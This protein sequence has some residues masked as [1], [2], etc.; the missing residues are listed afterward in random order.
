MKKTDSDIAKLKKV[1]DNIHKA[2]RLNSHPWAKSLFVQDFVKNNPGFVDKT[3]GEQIL[4]AL[5]D[6]FKT[7]LPALPPKRGVR[8]DARWSEFGFLAAK[9]FSPIL[10]GAPIPASF[11]EAWGRMDHSILLFVYGKPAADLTEAEVAHYALVSAESDITPISTISDWHRKGLQRL[12]DVIATRESYLSIAQTTESI[13]D[14]VAVN[15]EDENATPVVPIEKENKKRLFANTSINR[16]SVFRWAGLALLLFLGVKSWL[17]YNA[18]MAVRTDIEEL[19][20]AVELPPSMADIDNAIPLLENLQEDF[21]NLKR[22]TAPFIWAAPAFKWIPNYGCDIAAS[23]SFMRMGSDL[24]DITLDG[25]DAGKPIL[26]AVRSD[27]IKLSPSAITAMFVKANSQFV[28]ILKKTQNVRSV[29]GQIDDSCLSPFTYDIVVNKIDP[30]LVLLND[31][32]TLAVEIPQI[33]GASKE[34]PKTYLL[35]VQNE[36]ELRPTGGFL[37]AV[38]TVLIQNGKLGSIFFKDTGELDDWTKPYPVAPWQLREYMNSPVL[39]LRD[40]N[41]FTD[42]PTSALY[43]EQLYSYITNHSADGVIAFDQHMLV[44]ILRVIGPVHLQD[45]DVPISADNVISY[46]RAEKKKPGQ[47]SINKQNFLNTISAEMLRKV[48]N[49]DVDW[50]ALFLTVIKMLDE[51]HI[52]LQMDNP[53]VMSF[54]EKSKW[55]GVIR[56]SNGDFIMVVDANI[57]FNK[58]NA[59]INTE[60]SYDVDLTNLKSPLSQLNVTHTNTTESNTPCVHLYGY[61]VLGESFY[62]IHDC[63]WDYMRVYTMVDAKLVD[64]I[65]QFIPGDWMLNRRN[66]LPKVD[67]LEDESQ[68]MQVFGVLKVVPVAQAI[69]TQLDF[70]LPLDVVQTQAGTGNFVYYLKIQKQPGTV[71]IPFE[72]IIRLPKGFT[73]ESL[74]VDAVIK[75]GI[76][77][78]TTNLQLDREYTIVFRK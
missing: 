35:L 23:A 70:K 6:L 15:Q 68:G 41:W 14:A 2:D 20:N 26:D 50:E 58:T 31:T 27:E 64:S 72:L 77:T 34:G 1:L 18:A 10:F 12:M 21:G 7:M 16:K 48:L 38:G 5:A 36:D 13:S 65:T 47:G 33:A 56:P 53:V 45:V 76:V 73:V 25:Y 11:Q 32:L 69:T 63:Y 40:S 62:P 52:L 30:A 39:V 60:I 4:A 74:P 19:R 55:D 29:R 66:V 24:L 42:Y 61:T 71:A 37:T 57:G 67:I 17:I 75:S 22:E 8:L 51:R 3:H 46:M 28:S 44:E 9:Y 54:V 78:I 59:V 49:G 43:A